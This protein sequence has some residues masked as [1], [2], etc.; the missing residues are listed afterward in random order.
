MKSKKRRRKNELDRPIY[1]SSIPIKGTAEEQQELNEII[2][3]S[4]ELFCDRFVDR[5]LCAIAKCDCLAITLRSDWRTCL[6]IKLAP[7]RP[8]PLGVAVHVLGGLAAS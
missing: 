4:A 2:E 3:E 7:D 5:Y 6:H 1:V 8:V